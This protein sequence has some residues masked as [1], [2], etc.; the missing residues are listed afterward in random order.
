MSVVWVLLVVL[1]VCRE[2]AAP[3]WKVTLCL[4]TERLMSSQ[5]SSTVSSYYH[6][7][8]FLVFICGL[9]VPNSAKLS[10][11]YVSSNGVQ[12]DILQF[13]RWDIAKKYK[14]R[15]M[16][17]VLLQTHIREGLKKVFPKKS[18]RKLSFLT[19]ISPFV[20]PN[21]GFHTFGKTFPIDRFFET[22]P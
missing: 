20:F 4:C 13:N 2:A 7:Q 6:S 12:S 22:F 18:P 19:R 8:A 1:V 9:I 14:Q 15:K 3:G 11:F 21:L 5:S 16:E 17:K 10:K